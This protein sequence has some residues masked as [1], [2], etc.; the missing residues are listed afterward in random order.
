M[1][2][3]QLVIPAALR[4]RPQW[5]LWR[6]ERGTKIPYTTQGKPA[7]STNR[8]TWTTFDAAWRAWSKGGYTGVGYV[9]APDDE[10][11]GIDLDDCR[12]AATGEIAP[13]ARAILDSLD[14]YAEVSPS[15]TGVKVWA[16]GTLARAIKTEHVEVYARARYFTVTGQRLD[17]YPDEPQDAQQAIDALA[18]QYGPRDEPRPERPQGAAAAGDRRAAYAQAALQGE[19]ERVA[20]AGEGTRN[21]TLNAAAFSLGQLIASGV[22]DEFDTIDAL[23][24]AAT[25]AG[26]PGHEARATIKSGIR[27]GFQHPREIP[28][29][30]FEAGATTTRAPDAGPMSQPDGAQ[31]ES[32]APSAVMM[33]ALAALGYTF[34]LNLCNDIIEVNGEP[35]SDIIAAEIRTRARDYGLKG[36]R[37]LEDTYLSAAAHCAYHPIRDYLDGVQWDGAD[38][39][40]ALINYLHSD[41]PPVCYADGT[42]APLHAVYVM[43]WL[44]GAVAKVFEGAQNMML[45]IAGPQG[46]GKSTLARW[47][48]D[49]LPGYFIEA[50]INPNDKDNDVRLMSRFIWEVSELDATTRKADVSALKAF[51]TKQTV[52]V[53]KAYGRHDTVKPAIASM[54]GTVN[55]GA[56]FLSDETG[57]RRFWV[58]RLGQIDQ[59]Y[60]T[61]VPVDQLWAQAVALYRAGEPWHL[62]PEERA[63]HEIANA[64]Y[65]VESVL[66][67]WIAKHF[68]TDAGPS[69]RMTAADIVDHLAG[70]NVRLHGSERAQAMELSRVLKRLGVVKGR[71]SV[72]RWYEGIAPIFPDASQ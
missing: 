10:F 56:G 49:G 15:G 44:I 19:C 41:D 53:R 7:S 66:E 4:G 28:D 12:D 47:L 11:V 9:F 36:V 25:R 24:N 67:G 33:A 3:T 62:G 63:T 50:P 16:R 20:Q 57:S 42:Q 72:G 8:E 58:T 43:R 21:N 1:T 31:P 34:R 38:H 69:A 18:R 14:S 45:V 65:D 29:R 46:V 23:E 6:A 26:L 55:E 59:A 40:G 51:I 13:W 68:D 54:I 17:E 2:T 71:S 30:P 48:C 39:I 27:A 32:R 60:R 5:V 22:L 61:G 35:I 37:A 52:T 70:A 64:G